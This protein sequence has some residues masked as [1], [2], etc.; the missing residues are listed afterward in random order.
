LLL[1]AGVLVNYIDRIN[2][3]VAAPQLQ[4]QFG[5][6]DAQL[7]LL[8][9]AFFWAYALMQI[10]SGVLLDRFGVTRIG[11]LSTLLWSAASA[12]AA[13]AGGLGGLLLARAV[14]GIA[15]APSFPANAKAV[16]YWF[17]LSERAT[18]TAIFDA[19]AKFSNVI[20]VPLVA[21]VTVGFGWRWGFAVSA[22][23]SLCYF[24]LFWHVYRDPSADRH[25]SASE[26][27]LIGDGGATAEGRSSRGSAEMLGYLMRNRKVW[28][29]SF[30]FS[31]YGY[32]FYFMLTWLPG[33][34]VQT[35]HQTILQ[36]AGYTT[37]PWICATIADLAV[38]GWWVDRLIR[39]GHD[40]K[41]VRKSVLVGGMLAGLAMFGAA[42]TLDPRWAILWISISLSGLSAAA[43]VGWS[44][45]ALIAPRG[46]TASVGSIMNFMN[47]LMGAVAPM[48][49]GAIVAVT[50]AFAGAFFL[51]GI[52]LL[53]GILSY[54][55]LLGEIAP[56]PDPPAKQAS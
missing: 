11:R 19:A 3:S 47:N 20:G 36:S 35:M 12:L 16:G 50:H 41:R 45:P 37:I 7:G 46:A 21:M 40:A 55:F 6:G 34:L 25:L 13:I 24:A 1:G 26:R 32:C 42:L 33:Y 51:A 14:L 56:I 17:P 43:P 54:I 10:P 52:V 39:R 22:V 28:G 5:L 9:S 18:A 49:T 53:A 44:L 4:Q 23:L 8:F 27:G 29:L 15:E 31:C 30:G 2:L 38:G 48:V